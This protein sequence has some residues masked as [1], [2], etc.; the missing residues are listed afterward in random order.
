MLNITNPLNHTFR[1][2][3]QAWEVTV[4]FFSKAHCLARSIFRLRHSSK[5]ESIFNMLVGLA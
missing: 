2:G 1:K 4:P 3:H 5:A